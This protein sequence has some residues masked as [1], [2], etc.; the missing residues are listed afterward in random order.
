MDAVTS[1]AAMQA[2]PALS[3]STAKSIPIATPCEGLNPANQ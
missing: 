2:S 1:K 3:G